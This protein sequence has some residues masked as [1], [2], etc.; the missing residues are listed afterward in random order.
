M[1]QTQKLVNYNQK[2]LVNKK[3]LDILLLNKIVL[4]YIKKYIYN[5]IA[6]SRTSLK[7]HLCLFVRRC[8][9][10]GHSSNPSIFEVKVESSLLSFVEFSL[11]R[12]K[13][14]RLLQISPHHTVCSR[15][16]ANTGLHPTAEEMFCTFCCGCSRRP[17]LPVLRSLYDPV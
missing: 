15:H 9:R 2:R 12:C 13:L 8:R 4:K 17:P 6:P 7:I 3:C 16:R 14:Q 11:L 1:G 5:L 10:S